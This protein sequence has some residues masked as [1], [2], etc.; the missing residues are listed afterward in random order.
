MKDRI[1][2]VY[3]ITNIT[4]GDGYIGVSINPKGRFEDHCKSNFL[5]GKKIREFGRENFRLDILEFGL[6]DYCYDVREP[7]LIKSYQ[8]HVSFGK[9]YNVAWG[10]NKPPSRKGKKVSE[11]QKKRMS[12]RSRGKPGFIP[13]EETRKKMSRNRKGRTPWNKGITWSNPK[14]SA[15]MKGR[16][17]P[18]K[19]IPH[20]T[21]TKRKMS[22]AKIGKKRP[23]R[24]AEHCRKISEFN[25][26]R[27]HSEEI[28]K[29]NSESK[30]GRPWS[31][32]K[33]AA[34]EKR[35]G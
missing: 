4:D 27:K 11:W 30:R 1:A 6:E 16:P 2:Y 34:Y 29:K 24:S 35:W 33:R 19:G 9:G 22:V 32:A 8:T 31:A 20:S 17:P 12:E 7:L 28:R 21:E 18:N 25:K 14:R 26:G 13:T 3:K 23:P 15:I 10:G 5:I